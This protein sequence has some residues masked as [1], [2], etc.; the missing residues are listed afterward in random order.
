MNRVRLSI[1]RGLAAIALLSAEL[2]VVIIL[3]IAALIVFSIFAIRIF[4]IK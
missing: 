3:F 1:K 4:V 2:I